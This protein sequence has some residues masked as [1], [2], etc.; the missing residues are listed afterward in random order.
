MH[1]RAMEVRLNG[2]KCHATIPSQKNENSINVFSYS[3]LQYKLLYVTLS[4]IITSHCLSTHTQ[5]PQ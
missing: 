4:V 5:K 3:Q 2:H 1:P